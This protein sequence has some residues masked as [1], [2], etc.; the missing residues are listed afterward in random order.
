MSVLS[1]GVPAAENEPRVWVVAVGVSKYVQALQPLAYAADG[2][3]KLAKTLSD[4]R[5]QSTRAVILTTDSP[6]ASLQPTRTNLTRELRQLA[7]KVRPEDLVVFYFCGHGVESSGQQL[8][9]MMDADL[10]DKETIDSSTVGLGWLREKLEA[11][12]CN[13]RLLWLDACRE[14]AESLRVTGGVTGAVA[15]SR[16]FLTSGGGWQAQPGRISATLFGCKEGEKVYH[17]KRGSFFTEA[18]V[19]GLSGKAADREGQVTLASLSDYVRKRVPE[20]ASDELGPSVKQ[21]P[22]MKELEWLGF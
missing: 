5:P 20:A 15:M 10:T 16:D 4:A 19:D 11:M 13:G 9:L 1:A 21:E 12:P 18:L 3:N 8:L 7:Q 6:D 14:S 17:G 2:A 22:V